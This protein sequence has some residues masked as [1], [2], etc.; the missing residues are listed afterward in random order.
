M[1]ERVVQ[2]FDRRW[3]HARS[4][5]V[6]SA[7]Q[8]ELLLPADVGEVPHQRAHQRVVLPQQFGVVELDQPQCAVTRQGQLACE[9]VTCRH[10]APLA[11]W[12]TADATPRSTT[13]SEKSSAGQRPSSTCARSAAM[14][15]RQRFGGA[16]SGSLD[17]SDRRRLQPWVAETDA[18]GAVPCGGHRLGGL[19]GDVRGARVVEQRDEGEHDGGPHVVG[20]AVQVADLEESPRPDRWEQRGEVIVDVGLRRS[21]ARRATWCR[22]PSRRMAP[23]RSPAPHRAR[24][25]ASP[26]PSARSATNRRPGRRRWRRGWDRTG[27]SRVGSRPAAWCFASPRTHRRAAASSP[28]SR[29]SSDPSAWAR[30]TRAAHWS[31]GPASTLTCTDAVEVIIAAPAA[32]VSLA[33][34]NCSMAR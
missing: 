19:G 13:R 24:A 23:S 20:H 21:G 17:A 4:S 33:V 6:V 12:S 10:D 16:V 22:R 31:R 27:P 7:E 15:S 2:P 30:R 18:R 32:P 9:Q 11:R 29:S 28:R 25:P 5:T 26:A 8:P 14:T 34:K 1:H 3:Q